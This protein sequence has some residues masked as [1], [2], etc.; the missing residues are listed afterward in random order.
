LPAR[1][2]KRAQ[3]YPLGIRISIP[4][5]YSALPAA[6]ISPVCKWSGAAACCWSGLIP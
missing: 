3:D 2:G 4:T 5:G 6:A 1:L